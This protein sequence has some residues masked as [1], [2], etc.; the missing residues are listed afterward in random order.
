[1]RER[2]NACI[3]TYLCDSIV[4]YIGHTFRHID[5]PICQLM[6]LP[7]QRRL[8]HLR[9]QGQR[10]V[11]SETAQTNRNFLVALGM[12]VGE[13]IAGALDVRGHAGPVFR[14]G[15]GW[16]WEMGELGPGWHFAK[17]DKAAIACR[18]KLLLE[19]FRRKQG[20]PILAIADVIFP[21]SLADLADE[22]RQLE[23]VT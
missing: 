5:Q 1:M 9:L 6:S 22:P 21:E 7:L 16:F 2:Y 19:L 4:R 8:T 15:E 18:S 12:H 13:A 20:D 10:R 11:P 23:D 14:W 3:Q 17:N